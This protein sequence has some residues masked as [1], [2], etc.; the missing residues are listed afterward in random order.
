VPEALSLPLTCARFSRPPWLSPR[1]ARTEVLAGLVV[2]LALA[3]PLAREHGLS[4][5][6]AAVTLSGRCT[7]CSPVA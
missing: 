5:L 6:I 3:A 1:V 7:R 2:A 4:Y